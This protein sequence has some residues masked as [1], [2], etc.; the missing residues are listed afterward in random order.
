M[1]QID[2]GHDGLVVLG[3][4]HA[5]AV[6]LS[7]DLPIP[8]GKIVCKSGDLWAP[9]LFYINLLVSTTCKIWE[10]RGGGWIGLSSPALSTA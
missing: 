1:E 2:N 10:N 9:I 6:R 8:L 4:H 7:G 3:F 5:R